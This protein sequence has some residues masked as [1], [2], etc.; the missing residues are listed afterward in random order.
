MLGLN[1]LTI[2]FQA[3]AYLQSY[4]THKYLTLNN[5]NTGFEKSGSKRSMI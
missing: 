2:Y 1:H 5:D 3:I 4:T